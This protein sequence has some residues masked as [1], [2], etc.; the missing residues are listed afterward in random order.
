MV[1]LDTELLFLLLTLPLTL[2]LSLGE[3]LGWASLSG[4]FG[5]YPSSFAQCPTYIGSSLV[6]WPNQPSDP[7]LLSYQMLFLPWPDLRVD[8]GHVLVCQLLS[9]GSDPW[10]RIGLH[11]GGKSYL[12]RCDLSRPDAYRLDRRSVCALSISWSLGTVCV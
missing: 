8:T 6:V 5:I 4:W 9:S 12:P 7:F 1:S 3:F 10:P 11:T 2:P